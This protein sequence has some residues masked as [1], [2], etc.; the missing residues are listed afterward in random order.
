MLQCGRSLGST[1]CGKPTYDDY[2]Q[3]LAINEARG[4]SGIF[5]SLDC[6]HYEWKNCPLAWQGDFGDRDGKNSII[7]E[8]MADQS[9]YIW[10]IYFGLP[11]SNNDLNVLDQSPLIHDLLSGT[12]CDMTFEL[13]G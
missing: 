11:G 6:M 1:T 13:N 9:L 12:A 10:Y 7:L 4:F 2:R 3:K 8:A 5:G